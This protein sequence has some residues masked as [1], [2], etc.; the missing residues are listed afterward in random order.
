LAISLR[1]RW[2]EAKKEVDDKRETLHNLSSL[3]LANTT[4]RNAASKQYRIRF[5]NN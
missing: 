1:Q 3:L 5:F 2:S 4:I